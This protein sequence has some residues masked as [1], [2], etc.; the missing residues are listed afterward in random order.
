MNVTVALDLNRN[1]EVE[2]RNETE[3]TGFKPL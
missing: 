2:S 1:D 3:Y